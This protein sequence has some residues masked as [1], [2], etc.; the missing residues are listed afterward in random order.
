MKIWGNE[1]VGGMEMW[2]EI[3]IWGGNVEGMRMR[4]EW[5]KAG[6]EKGADNKIKRTPH[7]RESG[8]LPVC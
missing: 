7:S 4:G 5:V 2:E 6:I 8:N 3:G 1:D